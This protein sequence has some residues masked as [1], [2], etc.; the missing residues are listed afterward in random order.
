M[1]SS[2][3]HKRCGTSFL[4]FVMV[5]SVI[6]HFGITLLPIETKWMQILLRIVLLP[7]IAG[8]S[9]EF[10]RWAGSSDQGLISLL[11]KPGLTLQKLTTREPE[12]DMAQ[13][14]IQAVEAVFDWR[15]YL[16]GSEETSVP[17]GK[18]ADEPVPEEV[19]V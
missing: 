10:I 9:Y 1:K 17:G 2:R 6:I 11:S 15:A 19:S 12:P 5:V 4:L 8:I 16:A 3:Q 18:E 14:A 7:L 13:V